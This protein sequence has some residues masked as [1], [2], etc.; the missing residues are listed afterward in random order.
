PLTRCNKPLTRSNKPL[1]RCNKPLT[2]SNKPL[3]RCNKPLTRRP[4]A[5]P[6]DGGRCTVRGGGYKLYS[7]GSQGSQGGKFLSNNP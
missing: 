7:R 6:C 2:R 5:A 1:T 4:T 3:T